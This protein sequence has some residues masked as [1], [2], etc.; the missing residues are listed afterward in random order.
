MD[1]V[2]G[3]TTVLPPKSSVSFNP[4]LSRLRACITDHTCPCSEIGTFMHAVEGEML[5]ASTLPSKVRGR[6][7]CRPRGI[8]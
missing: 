5:C 6:L 8:R 7:S 1:S 2:E 3:S 4:A